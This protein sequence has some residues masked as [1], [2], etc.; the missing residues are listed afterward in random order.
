MQFCFVKL[1]C[2][3]FNFQMELFL[4]LLSQF[5]I[6]QSSL[7]GVILGL[8]QGSTDTSY[9]SPYRVRYVSCPVSD[10]HLLVYTAF[11]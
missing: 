11:A 8:R 3:I 5:H 2:M 10:T 4:P 6:C 9:L 1:I 7:L